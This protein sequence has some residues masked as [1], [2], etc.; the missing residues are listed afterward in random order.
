M[1]LRD[2]HAGPKFP[3][4]LVFSDVCGQIDVALVLEVVENY[5]KCILANISDPN[6]V[7]EGVARKDLAPS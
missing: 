6:L 5:C 1:L 2:G 4:W 7:G 3:P